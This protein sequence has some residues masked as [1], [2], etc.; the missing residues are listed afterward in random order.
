MRATNCINCGAPLDYKRET[1]AYCSTA[2]VHVGMDWGR[3]STGLFVSAEMARMQ[4]DLI[5]VFRYTDPGV[6]VTLP[7]PVKESIWQNVIGGAAL[8]MGRLL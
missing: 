3:K 5:D 6:P 7:V 4:E 2:I 8:A 1:C